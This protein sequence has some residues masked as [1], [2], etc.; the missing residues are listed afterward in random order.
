MG[1]FTYTVEVILLD[2]LVYPFNLVF[3]FT[4]EEKHL[5]EMN[6]ISSV[7]PCLYGQAGVY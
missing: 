5:E 4:V 6:L 7:T 2:M 1:I 3:S